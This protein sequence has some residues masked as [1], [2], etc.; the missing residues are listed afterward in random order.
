MK[1][2]ETVSSCHAVFWLLMIQHLFVYGT[3]KPGFENAFVAEQAG[4]LSYTEGYIKG[5]DLYHLEPENYPAIVPGTGRVYGGMMHFEDLAKALRILDELEG[6]N[7]EPPLYRREQVR[8]EPLAQ[9]AWVYVY[10]YTIASA[11][12]RFYLLP[13][14]L[15]LGRP[16]R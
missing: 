1:R 16:H 14:G 2:Q 8:V 5:Y 11:S 6:L 15:W 3:L 13:D 10:N 4:M 7:L 9:V 12:E